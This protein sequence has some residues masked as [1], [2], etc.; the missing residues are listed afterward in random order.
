MYTDDEVEDV[1]REVAELVDLA[2]KRAERECVRSDPCG[3]C[4]HFDS[5]SYW[6]MNE[7]KSASPTDNDGC[8]G[9]QAIEFDD[10]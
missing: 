6:C 3:T 8:D 10:D 4:V 2:Q 1:R 9:Y 5:V 7:D